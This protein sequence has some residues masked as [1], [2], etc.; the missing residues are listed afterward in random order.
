MRVPSTVVSPSVQPGTILP[1]RQGSSGYL[2]EAAI[3]ATAPPQISAPLSMLIP[4]SLS[5]SSASL[6][7]TT[8]FATQLLSQNDMGS[9]PLLAVYEELVAASQV[10]Y[11][12]SMAAEPEPVSNNLFAKMLAEENSHSTLNDIIR[13]MPKEIM[14][15]ATQQVA[16]NAPRAVASVP[17]PKNRISEASAPSYSGLRHASQSYASTE[18]RNKTYL[19]E[20]PVEAISG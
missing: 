16:A 8:M 7:T 17:Q 11:K 5:T 14:A 18:V 9:E 3:Q 10:K 12:P 6:G 13:Q 20:T 2:P 4:S 19:D 15:Q 1:D